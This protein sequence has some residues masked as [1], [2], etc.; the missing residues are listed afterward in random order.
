MQVN[1]TQ[2]IIMRAI[3]SLCS[4]DK[5][6]SK[7]LRVNP[8]QNCTLMLI[9]LYPA[10]LPI[11]AYLWMGLRTTT[12]FGGSQPRTSHSDNQRLTKRS[13]DPPHASS[14]RGVWPQ[15]D[16]HTRA[17][18]NQNALYCLKTDKV[19]VKSWLWKGW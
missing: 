16:K 10:L 7:M 18:F 19:S 9:L 13:A 6:H 15:N 11:S 17:K 3:S 12:G 8:D 14:F 1:K 4:A 5:F 2:E